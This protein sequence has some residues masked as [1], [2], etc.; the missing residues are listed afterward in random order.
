MEL[1]LTMKLLIV[2]IFLTLGYGLLY[3]ALGLAGS[4]IVNAVKTTNEKC[5]TLL[6]N[7]VIIIIYHFIIFL[8]SILSFCWVF[9]KIGHNE[10][11]KKYTYYIFL[12]S[13]FNAIFLIL[14]I[15]L[16]SCATNCPIH[17]IKDQDNLM[18]YSGLSFAAQLLFVIYVPF[19]ANV[20]KKIITDNI[21]V[22]TNDS[23]RV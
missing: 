8:T 14:N 5:S 6:P 21:I 4:F 17:E 16:M 19:S 23:V 11:L 7:V 18:V 10:N 9:H 1:Y 15:I 20:F 12:L 3:F 22:K 2:L 13:T